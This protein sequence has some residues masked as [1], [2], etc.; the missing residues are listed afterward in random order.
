MADFNLALLLSGTPEQA[1]YHSEGTAAPAAGGPADVTID[2]AVN[3]L[4]ILDPGLM[5]I[6]QQAFGDRMVS[7]FSFV[8]F[9]PATGEYTYSLTST[10]TGDILLFADYL[11]SGIR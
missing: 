10:G 1:A 9:D 11:H 7:D 3:P 8:S 4:K 2:T 6:T 5:R